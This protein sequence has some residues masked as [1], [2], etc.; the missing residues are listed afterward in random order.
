MIFLSNIKR[1]ANIAIALGILLLGIWITLRHVSMQ[2]PYQEIWFLACVSLGPIILTLLI[3]SAELISHNTIIPRHPAVFT[4]FILTISLSLIPWHTSFAKNFTLSFRNGVGYYAYVILNLFC[5]GSSCVVW[6][7]R[8]KRLPK[9]EASELRI[10][11]Y[12]SIALGGAICILMLLRTFLPGSIPKESSHILV[13]S[14]VLCLAYLFSSRKVFDA[15]HAFR[16]T[17]RFATLILISASIARLIMHAFGGPNSFE[18]VAMLTAGIALAANQF[19]P[20]IY[21]NELTHKINDELMR[22]KIIEISATFPD[23]NHLLKQLKELIAFWGET[24]VKYIA[25]IE[26]VGESTITGDTLNQELMS[27]LREVRWATPERLR[28]LRGIKSSGSIARFMDENEIGVITLSVDSNPIVIAMTKRPSLKPFSRREAQQLIEY[29]SLAGLALARVRLLS[30]VAHSDRL[31]TLGIL[32]ASIAHEIRN[33]LFAIKTFADLLPSHYESPEFRLQ[34]SKMVG[35]EATRIDSLLTDMMNLGKPRMLRIG[36]TSLNTAVGDT[37]DLLV[38]KIRTEGIE[39]K[40]SLNARQDTIETDSTIVRQILLNLC[41]NAIQALH[42]FP[43]KR[44]IVVCTANTDRG[45]EFVIRDSGPGIPLKARKKMFVRFHTSKVDGTGL[46]LWLCRELVTSV[47]G[48]LDLDPF[49]PG[50]G[51][52]FRMTLPQSQPKPILLNV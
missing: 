51:A 44:S 40:R 16:I 46:G 15:N 1:N 23:E 47:G 27:V 35:E 24:A 22:I 19:I 10:I 33:P 6:I 13:I 12:P 43:G 37:L 21:K 42:D 39:C 32:G 30:H 26:D 36:P 41:L 14:Y 3:V 8:S 48:S 50:E 4:I 34:F 20:G 7:F 28:K 18:I 45:F 5:Y 49:V 29:A 17:I 2:N 11:A 9:Q 25:P 52:T 38:Q 31:V